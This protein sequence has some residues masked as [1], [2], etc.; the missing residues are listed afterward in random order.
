[1]GCSELR[2]AFSCLL[3]IVLLNENFVTFIHLMY[4]NFKMEIVLNI[5]DW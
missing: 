2:K 3:A 5:W 4:N 1:M